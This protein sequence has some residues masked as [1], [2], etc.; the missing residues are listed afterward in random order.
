MARRKRGGR[1]GRTKKMGKTAINTT[2]DNPFG[3]RMKRRGRKS[4]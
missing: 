3:G 1:K 2:M 4:R